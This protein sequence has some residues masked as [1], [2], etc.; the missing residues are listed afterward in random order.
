MISMNT[1]KRSNH[2]SESS[3][4]F[5]LIEM[6]IAVA[7]MAVM[8]GAAV[9]VASKVLTYKARKATYEELQFLSEAS[10][11]FFRDTKRLPD[12]IEELLVDPGDSGWSGPYLPG[13]VT[14]QLSGLT[15]YQVDAWSREYQITIAGDV[16]SISSAGE[17]A[18]FGDSSD[19]EIDL[20]VTW[21]RREETLQ[22]LKV[23][24]QAI[25]LYNGQFQLTKPLST[26][27]STALDALVAAG[28]LPARGDYV[29]DGWGK[30]Y[31]ADP[32]GKAPL[33][34]VTSPSLAES[35]NVGSN[36]GKKDKAKQEKE[37]K[38][39]SDG[40]DKSDDKGKANAKGQ[41][42]AKKANAAQKPGK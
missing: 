11:E 22:E 42:D 18:G 2:R 15:G 12:S 13:V 24:N 9:P 14:D 16:L 33:V 31:V 34:K 26:T 39:K 29:L 36:S 28:F 35:S 32:V 10:G 19:I 41:S 25:V 27:W 20:N 7:I 38:D 30:D 40:K 3:H 8:L 4:G 5:T 23:I 21:I 6:I 17:D 1:L 37:K